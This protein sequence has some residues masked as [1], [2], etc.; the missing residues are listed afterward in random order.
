MVEYEGIEVVSYA[1]SPLQLE[2]EIGFEM[3][4]A[5]SGYAGGGEGV[6]G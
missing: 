1:P 4:D 3:C 5:C 6:R 2:P